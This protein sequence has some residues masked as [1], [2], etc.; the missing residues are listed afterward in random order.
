[1][2]IARADVFDVYVDRKDRVWLLDFAPFGGD[3]Q[4]LLFHWEELA[5]F[6][7]AALEAAVA[8]LAECLDGA[9][10]PPTPPTADAQPCIPFRTV[11]SEAMRCGPLTHHRYPDDLLNAAAEISRGTRGVGDALEQLRMELQQL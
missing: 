9:R 3:T 8:G 5:D 1:M 4:P 10:P 7:S 2:V 11:T 6:D